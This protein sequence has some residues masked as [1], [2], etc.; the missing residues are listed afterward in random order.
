MDLRSPLNYD[1]QTLRGDLSGGITSAVVTLPVALAFGVASGLGA[2]AGLYGA[3]AA[4][5]FAALFGG[6]LGTIHALPGAVANINGSAFAIASLTLVVVSIWPRRLARLLPAPLLALVGGTLVGLLWL[7][8]APVIGPVP[9]GLPEPQL[10]FPSAGFMAG[11]LQPAL[12]LA[13]LASANSL[14]TSLVADFPNWRTPQSQPGTGGSG[15]RQHGRGTHRGRARSRG[16][17]GNRHQ[18]TGRRPDPGIGGLFRGGPVGVSIGSWPLRGADSPGRSRGPPD[19][20][21]LG[22]RRLESPHPAS[23]H[24]ARTRGSHA[25]HAGPDGV[26]RPGDRHRHRAD[27]RGNDSRTAVGTPGDGQRRIGA[28][29]GPDL[30]W[31]L[32]I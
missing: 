29:A 3:I 14:L 15:D 4:G 10:I 6:P 18:H 13:L 11:A 12:I 2:A 22:H 27:R 26:R 17:H 28:A 9:G 21:R 20:G 24:P 5:F 32:Y 19:Q 25:D 1:L 16:H 30:L 31:G 8:D 7:S 23:P